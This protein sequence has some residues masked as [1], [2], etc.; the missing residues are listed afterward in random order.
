MRKR[1]QSRTAHNVSVRLSEDEKSALERWADEDPLD[2]GM[3]HQLR[4]LINEEVERERHA[5]ANRAG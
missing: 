2:R 3:G 5:A 4:R 1:R